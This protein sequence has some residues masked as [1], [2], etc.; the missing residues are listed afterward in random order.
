VDT[1]EIMPPTLDREAF[2]ERVED[3]DSLPAVAAA[4]AQ[5]RFYDQQKVRLKRDAVNP[6]QLM[7]MGGKGDFGEARFGAGLAYAIPMFRSMQ[8]ERAF[9]EAESH[10]AEIEGDIRAARIRARVEGILDQYERE[11]EAFQVL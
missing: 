10:R 2:F 3:E 5:G 11:Q 9:A 7:L 1:A 6:F 4:E 8:G